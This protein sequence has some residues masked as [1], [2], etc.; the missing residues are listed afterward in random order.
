MP[1]LFRGCDLNDAFLSDA[2]LMNRFVGQELWSWG[3]NTNGGIGDLTT[4]TKSSPVQTISKGTNWASVSNSS[5]GDDGGGIKTD[6]TLWLWG[7]NACGQLGTNTI[8]SASSPVQTISAGTNWR[9]FSRGSAF[10]AALKTDGTLWAWGFGST[11]RLG[12]NTTTNRSSPSQTVSG[13]N[14]WKNVSAGG[15]TAGGIKTDGTLWLWGYGQAGGLGNNTTINRSSPVQ[16][17]AGGTNWKSL[18][19]GDSSVLLGINA[20][21][22]K[23]DG[24]LWVWGL[25]NIGQLGTFSVANTSSPVQTVS[26]GT[27]WKIATLGSLSSGSI[28]T[29]GTLWTWGAGTCGG[30]G[31]DTTISKSSPVQTVSGGTDWRTLSFGTGS[32]AIKTDGTLWTWGAFRIGNNSTVPRSSPVQTSAGGTAWRSISGSGP[33]TALRLTG[34]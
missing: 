14:N 11:G 17:L 7:S 13:G 12:N 5:N 2:D 22:I 34:E 24:T 1:I 8:V 20:G 3:G 10:T 4:I 26:G 6:G 25:N 28:K 27:S 9:S 21:G 16:T 29:D 18:V 15:L 31:D 30:L 19:I 32:A 23:T 33:I